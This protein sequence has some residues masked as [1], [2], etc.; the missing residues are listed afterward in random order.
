MDSTGIPVKLGHIL[1]MFL[2]WMDSIGMYY[3]QGTY[4]YST[5]TLQGFQLNSNIF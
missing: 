2:D 5:W 3:T 4:K 1:I